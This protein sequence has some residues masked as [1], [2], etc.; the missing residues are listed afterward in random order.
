[1]GGRGQA[2]DDSDSPRASDKPTS[3]DLRR[4]SAL[5]RLLTPRCLQLVI[6]R[7]HRRHFRPGEAFADTDETL[8]LLA[9]G[10]AQRE[11]EDGLVLKSPFAHLSKGAIVGEVAVFGLGPAS[12]SA[13]SIVAASD[14]CSAWGLIRSDFEAIL[15]ACP[16]D[17]EA[18]AQVFGQSAARSIASS[19]EPLR[20][21]R[22]AAL[23]RE[24]S[25]AFL[26]RLRPLMQDVLLG[27]GEALPELGMEGSGASMYIVVAG[28]LAVEGLGGELLR[29][30]EPGETIGEAIALDLDCAKRDVAARAGLEGLTYCL[31][32]PRQALVDAFHVHPEELMPI[33]D[34]VRAEEAQFIEVARGRAEWVAQC[35]MPALATTPLLAG[36]SQ[37]FLRAAAGQ[38]VESTYDEGF[39]IAMAGEAARAMVVVVE[40]AVDLFSRSGSRVGRLTAGGTFGEVE[41]LGVFDVSMVTACAATPCRVVELTK[42]GLRRALAGPSGADLRE[43][44][45][46]LIAGKHEQLSNGM[47]LCGL[48]IG[49]KPGDASLK[50]VS[51]QA[52]RVPL[53]KREV[54]EPIPDSDPCG[55]RIGIF[56]SGRGVIELSS[57]GR[58]IEVMSVSPGTVLCEGLLA[59]FKARVRAT[60]ADCEVYRVRLSDLLAASSFDMKPP[61]W[62]L[63]FRLLEKETT[64]S[65][66]TRLTSAR[67]LAENRKAH[68]CDPCI[69]DWNKRRQESVKRAQDLRADRLA[70]V[71]MGNGCVPQL[72]LLPPSDFGSTSYRSWGKMSSPMPIFPA[73]IFPRKSRGKSATRGA[74]SQ[75]TKLP[76]INSEPNLRAKASTC[77][78]RPRR[79]GSAGIS[80]S[81]ADLAAPAVGVVS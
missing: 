23:F 53:E 20:L 80:A 8:Y 51:L 41:A 70:E 45:R 9:E 72:P 61:D 5:F 71:H 79:G 43:G 57:S 48:K 66:R 34:I 3:E 42:D 13:A 14:S 17:A 32:V 54:W 6:S 37:E 65:M 40:G 59:D 77:G 35:G 18:L 25:D 2:D 39:Q 38:A 7:F 62:F 33:E 31:R 44:F 26:A 1:M 4:T 22:Q 75:S 74:H 12:A 73:A 76:K 58:D 24:V 16:E 19:R 63:Q 67:G 29:I 55:P 28:S 27:A 81:S 30:A 21:V 15:A 69:N 50:T 64:K 36:C 68:P 47:P 56:V 11:N 46:Q 52:D 78:P 60:S 10:R 49:A